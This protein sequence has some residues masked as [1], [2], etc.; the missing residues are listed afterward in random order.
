MF[1][2]VPI[3]VALPLFASIFAAIAV[4]AHTALRRVLP[5]PERLSEHHEVPGFLMGVVG[6]LYS[7]VLGFL[8]GTV[9]T[10]FASA[11]QTADL[12]AGYVAD[13]FNFAAQLSPPQS[14]RLQRL[15]AR[16]A[17]AV[18][19]EDWS[20]APAGKDASGA[21]LYEAVRVAVAVPPARQNASSAAI[22]ES[23]TIR[24]ALIDSLRQIGDTRR[25]RFV[26]S[27]SRLP[28]G[29]LEALIL[30]AA[31]VVAFT[32]LFGVRSYAKQMIMTALLAGSIGLFFGLVVELSTP[33]SGAI[34]V[35]RDALELVIANNHM[36]AFAK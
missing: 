2:G 35:S 22:L 19:D 25:L 10:A 16:Y 31:A 30:G 11:Q 34:H 36:A 18:R 7:V 14:T 9:W 27:Q 13:A 17:L 20:V 32:F 15:L 24:T 6:V 4:A 12:E 3:L 8:V 26:Q 5:S 21:V 28:E 33:Y 1:S 23:N 29:M